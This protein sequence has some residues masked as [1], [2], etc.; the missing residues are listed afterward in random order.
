[1]GIGKRVK[2]VDEAAAAG[3]DL[4]GKPDDDGGAGPV[5]TTG[6]EG[7]GAA[8]VGTGLDPAAEADSGIAGGDQAER[9]AD[10]VRQ[11]GAGEPAPGGGGELVGEAGLQQP[12]NDQ[13]QAVDARGPDVEQLRDAHDAW[14]IAMIRDG[15]G[16]GAEHSDA[17]RR[18]PML[19]AWENLPDSE[20]GQAHLKALAA[21]L[22]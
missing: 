10:A 20:A 14:C 3:A 5:L 12:G 1:M 6:V 21:G 2:R 13:V 19:V 8:A 17:D 18:S 15:W 22:S 9:E 16:H 4:P 11:G 7:A